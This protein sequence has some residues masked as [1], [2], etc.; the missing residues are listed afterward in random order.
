LRCRGPRQGP[1]L[2][3]IEVPWAQTRPLP[4]NHLDS[5]PPL[6]SLQAG[7]PNDLACFY[8]TRPLPAKQQQQ[9][10]QQFSAGA[11]QQGAQHVP[12]MRKHANSCFALAG[13]QASQ[14]GKGVGKALINIYTHVHTECMRGLD[15]LTLCQCWGC[16]ST[17]TS[18]VS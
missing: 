11:P 6:L 18:Q 12:C 13:T 9:Q 3:T 4:A 7:P 15:V 2:L 1:Y 16:Q 8:S 10:Q 14:K 17:Y 5:L